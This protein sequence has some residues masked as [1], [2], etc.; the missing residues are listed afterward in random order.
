MNSKLTGA[1]DTAGLSPR[2]PWGEVRPQLTTDRLCH[3]S[4]PIPPSASW[5]FTAPTAK[6]SK[7]SAARSIFLAYTEVQPEAVC[8]QVLQGSTPLRSLPL[9]A[10]LLAMGAPT[11]SCTPCR[12]FLNDIFSWINTLWNRCLSVFILQVINQRKKDIFISGKNKVLHRRKQLYTEAHSL[13]AVKTQQDLQMLLRWAMSKCSLRFCGGCLRCPAGRQPYW[14][15]LQAQS[16][17]MCI[18]KTHR[19]KAEAF[20]CYQKLLRWT[21]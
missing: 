10:V 17:C 1:T 7:T 18:S 2:P 12:S 21:L 15:C 4:P 14:S 20:L 3:R 16:Q 11:Y 5:A 8:P 6:K 19:L 9:R 13:S